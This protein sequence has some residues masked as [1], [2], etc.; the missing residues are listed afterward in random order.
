MSYETSGEPR[1]WS[2][3]V[4]PVV[5]VVATVVLAGGAV[6][7]WRGTQPPGVLLQPLPPE[8]LEECF[9]RSRT[10]PKPSPLSPEESERRG[11]LPPIPLRDLVSLRADGDELGL[12]RRLAEYEGQ[13]LP[14]PSPGEATSV[15]A[16]LENGS[17]N[18][19]VCNPG[20]GT[21]YVEIESFTSSPPDPEAST[22]TDLTGQSALFE[23][24]AAPAAAMRRRSQ[25]C[26]KP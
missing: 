20:V 19:T 12:I 9:E 25:G 23:A 22:S 18:L 3:W 14:I 1:R 21:F 24:P 26:E 4:L 11:S 16:T 13:T 5:A 2:R 10:S 7:L 8:T 17:L 6:A 15:H